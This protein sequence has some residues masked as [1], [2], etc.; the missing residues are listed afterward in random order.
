MDFW[1]DSTI[2]LVLDPESILINTHYFFDSSLINHQVFAD[3][4]S[5]K[6]WTW[7]LWIFKYSLVW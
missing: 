3:R 4:L 6:L 5:E 1:G 2:P 7:D